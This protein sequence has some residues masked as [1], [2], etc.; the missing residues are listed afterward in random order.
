[1]NRVLYL[2]ILLISI[3]GCSNIENSLNSEQIAS[4]VEENKNLNLET[5]SSVEKKDDKVNKVNL[6]PI[7]FRD[8]GIYIDEGNGEYIKPLMY[9]E[10]Q[11]LRFPDKLDN[12]Y[13]GGYRDFGEYLEVYYNSYNENY[14]ESINVSF[15]NY[16]LKLTNKSITISLFKDNL[17]MSSNKLIRYGENRDMTYPGKMLYVNFGDKYPIIDIEAPF[18]NLRFIPKNNYSLI[19][20]QTKEFNINNYLDSK[21]I[22]YFY[23]EFEVNLDRM[24]TLKAKK[25]DAQTYYGNSESFIDK[26]DVK[27]IKIKA[28]GYGLGVIEIPHEF[29]VHFYPINNSKINFN[30]LSFIIKTPDNEFILKLKNKSLDNFYF[31]PKL[32]NETGKGVYGNFNSLQIFDFYYN[33]P[34]DKHVDS[35]FRDNKYDDFDLIIKYGEQKKIISLKQNSDRELNFKSVPKFWKEDLIN[36]FEFLDFGDLTYNYV[37]YDIE[38]NKSQMIL[39]IKL[40]KK[41]ESMLILNDMDNDINYWRNRVIT[42]EYVQNGEKIRDRNVFNP[43]SDS[44]FKYYDESYYKDYFR[45]IRYDNDKKNIIYFGEDA[46]LRINIPDNFKPDINTNISI[47]FYGDDE[48]TLEKELILELSDKKKENRQYF[49]ILNKD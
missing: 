4:V 15:I 25:F 11:K 40:D 2:I 5:N 33:I 26:I 8:D 27:F 30:K 37:Y 28:R 18:T 29:K 39:E 45:N 46:D 21:V 3:T 34:N 12:Y 1:M 48:I 10:S 41:E 16:N 13:F 6:K 47:Y 49:N 35:T 9:S 7:E 42:I 31:Q 38:T 43:R 36:D 32:S 19:T 23:D 44:D 14:S 20:F 17:D 24:S 22:K